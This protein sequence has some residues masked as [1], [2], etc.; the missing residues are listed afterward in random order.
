M[1]RIV[2]AR[3]DADRAAE[4]TEQRGD[5]ELRV[6]D[7]GAKLQILRIAIE[8]EVVRR[9]ITEVVRA[10]RQ[11]RIRLREQHDVQITRGPTAVRAPSLAH[12]RLRELR[13]EAAHL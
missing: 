6:L 9:R 7:T 2:D 3:V 11:M 5:A 4:R 10:E 1:L 12:I 8:Q 13:E